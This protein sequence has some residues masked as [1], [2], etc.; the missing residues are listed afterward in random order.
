[1]QSDQLTTNIPNYSPNSI[2][3]S[4]KDDNDHQDDREEHLYQVDG[5]MDTQT[6]TDSSKYDENKEPDNNAHK[7]QRKIY[8][9]ADIVR[10]DMTKQTSRSIKKA[11]RKRESKSSS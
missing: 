4:Q 5:T 8:A 7:R 6:P 3:T 10:K 1:M 9:P 2:A 11:T